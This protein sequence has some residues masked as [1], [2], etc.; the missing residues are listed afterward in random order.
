M[1]IKNTD[2]IYIAGHGGLVGSAVMRNLAAR[3]YTNVIGR[4]RSELDLLS[5]PDT[6]A[7]LKQQ[8]PEV[9]ILA[10]AHVGG[11]HANNTFRTDF[12]LN[13]LRIQNNVIG[14][15]NKL[16]IPRLIFLGSSCI[17]PKH[18][19]QPMPE[20]CLLQG[21]LEYTN[22]PYALAKIAGLE[23]VNCIRSQYQRNYFSVMP[24]NLYGPGDSFH[25][26]NSH[27]L[28]ALLQRFVAAKE[29]NA[30]EIKVW[31]TGAPLREFM[32]VDDCADA[33]VHLME[34]VQDDTLKNIAELSQNGWSHINVGSDEEISIRDLATAIAAI[35]EYRGKIYFDSSKP[36]GT[37]RKLLDCSL[38]RNHFGWQPKTKL[39]EGLA[40]T[41]KWYL[42][43]RD[44]TRK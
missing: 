21:A 18:A 34:T 24:T 38:L 12:L 36:D 42:E 11:I 39:R 32:F 22:R 10:A 9:I 26:E 8:M 3:G 28:P 6:Y 41:L 2:R 29:Q 37:A 5:E 16:G 30:A 15:S 19:P 4:A 14:S 25:P 35:V 33:I 7:F 27:V 43:H 44:L 40:V 23:L 20:S 1:G 31:G 13:N 17:Y